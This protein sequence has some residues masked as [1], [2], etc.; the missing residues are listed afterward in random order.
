MWAW[1]AC[2]LDNLQSEEAPR[3]LHWLRLKENSEQEK[4]NSEPVTNRVSI[5]I[6]C[7]SEVS[8][9]VTDGRKHEKILRLELKSFQDLVQIYTL[10]FCVHDKIQALLGHVWNC[11]VAKDTSQ[12]PHFLQV[13]QITGH[14]KCVLLRVQAPR[15]D[16]NSRSFS[17]L[18]YVLKIRSTSSFQCLNSG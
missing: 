15:V 6:V 2:A 10:H 3:G 11:S 5:C 14:R 8:K 9:S 7:L 1:N 18:L 12:M 4:K 17:H 16:N 13:V